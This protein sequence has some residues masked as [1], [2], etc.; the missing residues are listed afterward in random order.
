MFGR[1][2]PIKWIDDMLASAVNGRGVRIEW[3]GGLPGAE[4]ELLLR[5][6]GVRCW[7][8]AYDHEREERFGVHVRPSQAKFAAGL[9]GGAGCAVVVGPRVAP[10]RPAS[11]WGVAAPAQGL[12]GLLVDFLGGGV[13]FRNR[14]DR[15]GG[16]RAARRRRRR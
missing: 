13:R 2:D 14:Q 6:Y 15:R 1:I 12:S 5:S 4:G 3:I 16:E 10:I 7:R 9:L 11:A 8:R